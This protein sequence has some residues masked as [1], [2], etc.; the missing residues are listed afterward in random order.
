ME[1]L[2]QNWL[3]IAL[4]VGGFFLFTRL[5]GMGG[6]GMSHSGSRR[7]D[8]SGAANAPPA[9]GNHPG[10]LFDPVSRRAF[11]AGDMPFSTVYRGRAYYFES[12]ENRDA[13]EADPEKH[14]GASSAAG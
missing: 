4:A 10:T 8:Q 12:R 3:W 5:G 11:P 14:L 7:R 2:S 9:V 13:F 1:W 6:C